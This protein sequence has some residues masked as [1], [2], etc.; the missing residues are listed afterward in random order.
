MEKMKHKEEKASMLKGNVAYEFWWKR[1]SVPWRTHWIWT[2]CRKVVG[3][4]EVDARI[5]LM[6]IGDTMLELL[7]HTSPPREEDKLGHVV[8]EQVGA[9]NHICFELDDS[10]ATI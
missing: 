6:P 10:E 7:C 8:W 9:I 3:A 4:N 1:L 5:A 2:T